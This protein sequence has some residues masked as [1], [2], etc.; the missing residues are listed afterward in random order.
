M[1]DSRGLCCVGE[2]LSAKELHCFGAVAHGRL[3]FTGL[4]SPLS[5]YFL[6]PRYL[7]HYF[8]SFVSVSCCMPSAFRLLRSLDLD[9][10]GF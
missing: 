5:H 3:N 1:V 2:M 8:I 10:G 6:S 9:D 7:L 4:C